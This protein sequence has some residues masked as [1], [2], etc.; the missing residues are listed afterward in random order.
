MMKPLAR[1]GGHSPCHSFIDTGVQKRR[2]QLV[3]ALGLP[4][5]LNSAVSWAQSDSRTLKIG[6]SGP[7][8]GGS[9]PMGLSMR[10]GVHMAAAELNSMG[11]ILGRRIE[12]VERNDRAN[13]DVGAAIAREFIDIE[14]VAATI[15]IVNTGVG[16]ASID[17]YQKA[18][19]PLMIAVST[20]AMLTQ[21]F[22]PPITDENY[23][24]RVSPTNDME[25]QVLTEELL[26]RDLREVALLADKT[27][28]GEAG[29]RD[30]EKWLGTR[31]IRLTG[32]ERFA[33]G[34][35]DMRPMLNRLR[36]T[37]PQ[38][39]VVWGIGPEMAQIARDR[40]AIGWPI[41]LCGG[42]T[43]SMSNF[44][45]GA[46][47]AGD[48]TLMTQT[49]IQEGGL[50]TRNAFLLSYAR[51]AGEERIPSP[52]SAAQGYDGMHLLAAGMRQAGQLEG[53]AIKHA[54]EN[55]RSPL[56]GVVTEYVRPFS[57]QDHDAMSPRLIVMGMVNGGRVVHAYSKDA[58]RGLMARNKE[59]ASR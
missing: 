47:R 49:F 36:T 6:L 15:G 8:T 18:Q 59:I 33:I 2:R 19:V 11:G 30:L 29:K 34:T 20:G 17:L 42:W 28:Y 24:F 48:G 14:R 7:F 35:T 50:S 27:P 1:P 10:N 4:W 54:L 55:L 45:D 23:I 53:K 5:C 3:A 12:L 38:A 46:G 9:A 25:A 21:K 43:F 41:P 22:A 13:P 52:M 39:L 31:G 37:R 56:P 32:V 26:R 44:I 51:Y 40:I 58:Q 16:L 57:K